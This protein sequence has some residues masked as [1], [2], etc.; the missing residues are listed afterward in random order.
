MTGEALRRPREAG[1]V[2]VGLA[3]L[4]DG[5]L[6]RVNAAFA[7]LV[8]A[9]PAEVCGQGLAQLKAWLHPEE[10]EALLDEVRVH[11]RNA[12]SVHRVRRATG[13]V[14]VVAIAAQRLRLAGADHLRAMMTPLPGVD[15][16]DLDLRVTRARVREAE[17]A[18]GF[19][20]WDF[21]APS[22]RVYWSAG[23]ASLLGARER[24][25]HGSREDFARIVHPDD[26]AQYVEA[27]ASAIAARRAFQFD[28]RLLC[29]DGT[30]RW[31]RTRGVPIFAA[32]G[33]LSGTT[34]IVVDVDVE[35]RH[36]AQA[37]LLAQVI[38]HMAEG[39]ALV[40]T[41]T[42]RVV[43]ANRGFERMFGYG[44]GEL[45]GLDVALLNAHDGRAPEEVAREIMA[46]LRRRGVWHGEIKNRAKDGRTL[47]CDVSIS[48]FNDIEHGEVWIAVHR[49]ITETRRAEGERDAALAELRRLSVS[50]QESIESERRAIARD[51]HD[52]L[53]AALT[54]LRM[55]LEALAREEGPA[56]AGRASLLE[57]AA[58][59]QSALVQSRAICD[60]LRPPILDDLG[61]MEACRWHVREWSSASGIRAV[62]RL[63]EAGAAL[64]AGLTTDLFRILQEL[65]TNVA[66]HSGAR[67]VRVSV[68][69]RGGRVRLRVAD[70][71]HGFDVH[72][73]TRGFGLMG[74][75]ERARQHGGRVQ[76]RSS[77]DGTVIV[78]TVAL[79]DK[80]W[81]HA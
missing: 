68:A 15:P 26:L 8:G 23:L 59:A 66:R 50:V 67:N 57:L 6:V 28:Y 79:G 2:A 54:G 34:G 40:G 56:R 80:A 49:D 75:R 65:L 44:P 7:G 69:V 64:E 9:A 19:G 53:G 33:S 62:A 3:R 36:E 77:A 55:R 4:D 46:E 52:Q 14:L 37:R 47:W 71:G 39:V 30:A 29:A 78:V 72:T 18:A 24:P 76:L 63:G 13:G 73:P 61:L 11:G 38:A 70:D 42:G 48:T 25:F 10:I 51:I 12:G 17:R 20:F 35:R 60:R 22:G 32:D 1:A 41:K 16:D 43:L 45:S 5:V 27:R 74:L 31:V 58:T 21:D 81:A